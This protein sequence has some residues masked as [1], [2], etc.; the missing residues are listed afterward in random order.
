MG[1][2]LSTQGALVVASAALLGGCLSLAGLDN[3]YAVGELGSGGAVSTGGPGTA[4]GTTTGSGGA[5]SS[6]GSATTSAS[7]SGAGGAT[8]SSGAGGTTG[9]GGATTSSGTGGS[10]ATG[11]G[12]A[13]GNPLGFCQQ[14]DL[15]ACWEFEDNADDGS[16]ANND[17]TATN[18]S[19][20]TGMVGKAVT[21]AANSTLSRA[22]NASW[23]MTHITIELW[24]R[25]TA[26]PATG[27][28]GIID[29]N[30]QWGVFM[31]PDR[32]ECTIR[33]TNGPLTGG[34]PTNN[35]WVHL[36]C[37]NDGSNT[38]MYIDGV[39]V[40]TDTTV[41]LDG[42][43]SGNPLE[44]GRNAPSGDNFIGDFDQFRV[45]SEARSQPQICD[46][47]GNNGC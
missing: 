23:A 27:R 34:T 5:S 20:G 41:G 28:Q 13:G 18:V 17:L 42:L 43:Q 38:Y 35:T 21:L 15:V 32:F 4:T 31:H 33:N 9:A 47:A 24:L 44:V 29:S 6:S 40:D 22:M 36:A 14:P 26:V 19:Y 25:P 8:T 1:Q 45:F 2:C 37:T 16:A 39:Q 10:G 46:A 30:G 11:G 12:G 3:D 7:S